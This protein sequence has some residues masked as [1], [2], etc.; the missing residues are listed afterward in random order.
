MCVLLCQEV[1]DFTIYIAVNFKATINKINIKFKLR[2]TSTLKRK[3][4]KTKKLKF[5]TKNN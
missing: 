2:K 3:V 5:Y 1:S 4:K